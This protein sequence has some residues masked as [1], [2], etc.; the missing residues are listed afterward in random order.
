MDKDKCGDIPGQ[1]SWMEMHQ[2]I[3]DLITSGNNSKNQQDA[4]KSAWGVAAGGG[5]VAATLGYKPASLETL[6]VPRPAQGKAGVGAGAGADPG[7]HIQSGASQR[8]AAGRD[9]REAGGSSDVHQ[10]CTCPGC[11]YSNTFETLTPRQSGSDAACQPK[12][13]SCSGLVSLSMC[14][15][16]TTV[17]SSTSTS[18]LGT[19]RQPSD[20]A[21]RATRAQEQ[22][23]DAPPTK[24]S[25][26]T[27]PHLPVFPCLCVHRGLQT[28]A[29][30][31]S[32]QEGADSPLSHTHAHHHF[33]HHH[34]PLT[35]CLT[36][37]H[38]P[39][40]S[41]PFPCLSCSL[42]ACTQ[43]CHH[44]HRQTQQQEEGRGRTSSTLLSLH[45]CMHC[46]AT[47]S[48]P[49]Q[50]L[51]HQRSEHAHK[52]S[53]FLCTECGRAFNSHSNL[54]IHLNVHTGA[55][56]YTCSDCGK[57]FSQSGAL[58]IHRRI[59]TGERPYSC[60]FCG[61]GFPHL[62]GVR[63]HQRTHTGE[64]P[65]RCNQC[66]KCFTQSGALKIHTRIH[67][68]ERPFICSLCGKAFSNRSGIR[69][70]YRTVHGL[71]PEHTGEAGAGYRGPAGRGC[72]PGRPRTLPSTTVGL[73][74][75]SIS[76]DNSH[77]AP[78]SRDSSELNA[79]LSGSA[80]L[81]GNE[82]KSQSEGANPGSHREGLLY[83]CEDCGLRF[84][85]AP[86][87]NRHQTLAHYSHEGGEEDEEEEA[88]GQR[89]EFRTNER[90]QDN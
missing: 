64:K 33:H 61:R 78:N 44:Q 57:S 68:G 73:N 66:G 75:A 34:C 14:L 89:K 53:G 15:P 60:G 12:D 48:R 50:L 22:N 55:R 80:A 17:P 43:V 11:P 52:P 3:G 27:F 16:D 46:S 65:Y 72:P 19:G 26:G 74:M 67:T 56:P 7:R 13:L 54:R 18:E 1:C 35:S 6:Q 39:Q 37:P 40:L 41:G 24:V 10:A 88:E 9:R 8:K 36:C 59:H 32:Q 38:P 83:A 82:H 81:G 31:L 25:S 23:S 86:S 45:P 30:I 76:E 85:D 2:F 4:V 21:D 20:D 47:F 49:S 70:H 28:C 29:Q 63:A 90:V 51:Q 79:A 77:A 42:P 69:F 87:R 62:A 58:K 71:A 84:K 5:G